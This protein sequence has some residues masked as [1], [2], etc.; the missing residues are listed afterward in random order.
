MIFVFYT[1]LYALI[2]YA[3]GYCILTLCRVQIKDQY[4]H[5]FVSNV[6]GAI[7]IVWI[8]AFIR[9]KGITVMNAIWIPTLVMALYAYKNRLWNKTTIKFQFK[10]HIAHWVWGVSLVI[11]S[12]INYLFNLGYS[13]SYPSLYNIDTIYY[14]R[15]S[16]FIYYTGIE[17]TNI[18]YLQ[19]KPNHVNPYHYFTPWL[20]AGL[21]AVF[22]IENNYL[23]RKVIVFTIYFSTFYIGLLAIIKNFVKNNTLSWYH[24]IVPIFF[25]FIKPVGLG[26]LTVKIYGNYALYWVNS[27]IQLP[28]HSPIM[29]ILLVFILLMQKKQYTIAVL[30]L[31]FIP[32]FYI[33][34]APAI[35]ALI[36]CIILWVWINKKDISV[37][38]IIVSS[39]LTGI[40]LILF[41]VFHPKQN[42]IVNPT[43]NQVYFWKRFSDF[44]FMN[45]LLK[46]AFE[47]GFAWL[48]GLSVLIFL[49]IL[50]WKNIRE[51]LVQDDYIR[52]IVYF[53]VVSILVSF[54]VWQIL[55]YISDSE[56][57]FACIAAPV[58]ILFVFLYAN[59][60]LELCSEKKK[61][62][63]V[64]SILAY[65][66]ILIYSAI[67]ASQN[68]IKSYKNEYSTEYI[69][70][71][72]NN[73][74]K[75]SQ[76]GAMLIDNKYIWYLYFHGFPKPYIQNK[77]PRDFFALNI[78][79][80][81]PAK[82]SYDLDKL[83]I[84]LFPF[85][86]YVEKQKAEKT[87]RNL[88]E[89]KLEFVK[90]YNINHIVINKTAKL[91]SIFLPYIQEK[92]TD[93]LSGE[94][95]Y[96]LNMPQK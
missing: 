17:S 47:I 86:Q 43:G 41:Y 31:L 27:L 66:L 91:D 64:L 59:L 53:L 61:V 2:L 73:K 28:K 9:T 55:Y 58:F 87:F 44:S 70:F 88:S 36:S 76:Y 50:L 16:E 8:T 83:Y 14:V 39:L 62:I 4:T 75:F 80:L 81:Q 3:I 34:T 18:D 84:P 5:L 19:I 13:A 20:Q 38:Y 96:F 21:N 57:F 56:Q 7:F 40:Y 93:R 94:T 12:I 42:Y 92:Y 32:V 60:L 90:K 15:L 72:R 68:E 22:Y 29:M 78:C 6:I 89:S 23:V 51:K 25:F 95:L 24:F 77:N 63:G 74:H 37:F 54:L 35:F 71:I 52:L 67:R 79:E 33:T 45:T 82:E 85:Y 11:L 49:S 30:S 69:S 26:G 10:V 65:G 48:L 46:D 1:F